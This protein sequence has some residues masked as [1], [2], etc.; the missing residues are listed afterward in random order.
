MGTYYVQHEGQQYGPLTREEL[1][2]YFDEGALF[3]DD[4]AIAEGGAQWEALGGLVETVAVIPE[5]FREQSEIQ[6]QFDPQP[7][8][9]AVTDV[10]I[11][12]K[13]LALA[14]LVVGLLGGG[15]ALGWYLWPKPAVALTNPPDKLAAS[16]VQPEP[17]PPKPKPKRE[18]VKPPALPAPP[19]P[20]ASADLFSRTFSA[21]T[22]G[23]MEANL[24]MAFRA[25]EGWG[26][27]RDRSAA[28]T[29][30]EQAAPAGGPVAKLFLAYL[31]LSGQ[32][33]PEKVAKTPELEAEDVIVAV[34]KTA[35]E[36][37]ADA[38]YV[39]G[40]R[41]LPRRATRG[42]RGYRGDFKEAIRRLEQAAGQGHAPA[43]F[44]L[45][46]LAQGR[47]PKLAAQWFSAAAAQGHSEALRRLGLLYFKGAGV[48]VNTNEAVRLTTESARLGNGQ[49]RFRLGV[50]YGQGTLVKKD[51]VQS[52]KWFLLASPTEPMARPHAVRFF[53]VLEPEQFQEA[54]VLAKAVEPDLKIPEF[55]PL[56]PRVPKPLVVQ[57][58]EVNAELPTVSVPDPGATAAAMALEG[59]LKG[60]RE[61][62]GEVLWEALPPSHQKELTEVLVLAG[63]RLDPKFRAAF[64]GVLS[65]TKN[66]MRGKKDFV[67]TALKV[68][69]GIPAAELEG[70]WD[71]VLAILDALAEGE[72]ADEDWWKDPDAAKLLQNTGSKLLRLEGG[73][74][75]TDLTDAK[76]EPAGMVDGV[77]QVRLVAGE[78]ELLLAMRQVGGKWLPVIFLDGWK[79]AIDAARAAL[80]PPAEGEVDML[81]GFAGELAVAEGH[82]KKLAAAETQG[83]FAALLDKMIPDVFPKG[84]PEPED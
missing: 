66:L 64:F 77:V 42:V 59:V 78:E 84:E 65:A 39:L 19:L 17:E 25:N 2:H 9:A 57:L 18:L 5:V 15:T 14:I 58:G 21:A 47:N 3:A 56:P 75:W 31:Y 69:E 32:A 81:E 49:S 45:G 48:T 33:P 41:N 46:G 28:V 62:K 61:G 68:E 67:L 54:I 52:C 23:N 38:Q 76:V 37:N 71:S 30:A 24:H 74:D 83:E 60:L 8:Q 6:V 22:N 4:W 79:L 50:M 43:Q 26:R 82:L 44:A 80:E 11:G 70:N 35:D 10:S 55:I 20:F 27:G 36:G 12:R 29:H 73:N 34:A 7:K 51:D 40:V 72:L 1:Q 16:T 13:R 53:N 63:K